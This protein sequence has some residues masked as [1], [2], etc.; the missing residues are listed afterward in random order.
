MPCET[1]ELPAKL[2]NVA[3]DSF[4]T[5]GLQHASNA[6]TFAP[7][8][9]CAAGRPQTRG[10]R[11]AH[12]QSAAPL[13]PSAAAA[14]PEQQRNNYTCSSC[15]DHCVSSAVTLSLRRVCS[16]LM[17]WYASSSGRWHGTGH[18]GTKSE[19]AQAR[20]ER[21]VSRR[22]R[23]DSPRALHPL[24]RAARPRPALVSGRT[25]TS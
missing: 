15:L 9:S 4:C 25:A 14:P 11:G 18:R 23:T 3:S 5:A 12:P 22:R 8:T 17:R 13:S 10:T 16:N 2:A 7:P 19:S 24:G 21:Q 20:E 6:M 1:R